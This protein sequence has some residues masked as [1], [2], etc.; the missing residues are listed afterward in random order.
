[1]KLCTDAN[2][3]LELQDDSG[4]RIENV[5]SIELNPLDATLNKAV[6]VTCTL[7]LS[8]I[9]VTVPSKLMNG[10]V[11]IMSFCPTCAKKPSDCNCPNKNPILSTMCVGF[12]YDQK[13]VGYVKSVC[14]LENSGTD[15]A[16]KL[17]MERYKVED[18]HVLTENGIA[19]IEREM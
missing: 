1:M 10:P 14:V 9:D 13:P 8:D 7:W 3:H 16:P 2:G 18:G 12:R 6:A 19:L 11:N 5:L 4:K 17:I 15:D